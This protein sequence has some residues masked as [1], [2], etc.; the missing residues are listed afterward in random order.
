VSDTTTVCA[1]ACA[2]VGLEPSF[3]VPI[4]NV[5]V[6]AG[7]TA[8]LPCS[9]ESLGQYKVRRRSSSSLT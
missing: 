4:V 6:V 5:T 3:D 1:L 8:V 7:Q 9:V 2:V